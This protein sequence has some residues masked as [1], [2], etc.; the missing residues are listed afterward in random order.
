[1]EAGLQL[2]G[3]ATCGLAGQRPLRQS[4]ARPQDRRAGLRVADRR[5]SRPALR[6]ASCSPPPEIRAL[7]EL[8][9]SR[10]PLVKEQTASANRIQRLI[11]RGHSKLGQVASNALGGRGRLR[12]R[13]LAEGA[14]DG[15]QLAAAG[16]RRIPK[17]PTAAHSSGAWHRA[18]AS[19]AHWARAVIAASCSSIMASRGARATTSWAATILR[20]VRSRGNANS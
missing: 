18:R 15:A 13:A 4:R 7:R 8:P 1:M 2:A 19:T 20:A 3:R 11:A 9:R 12:L 5:G 16:A 17:R 10:Q 14:P 6:P